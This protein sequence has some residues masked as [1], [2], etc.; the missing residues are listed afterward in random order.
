MTNSGAI[1]DRVA[2]KLGRL[3]EITRILDRNREDAAFANE[4]GGQIFYVIDTNVVNSFFEPFLYPQYAEIFQGGIWGKDYGEYE[5]F[6]RQ[7]CLLTAEYLMSG[8]LPGQ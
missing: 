5:F 7:S 6:N 4:G 8:E 1:V 2:R 3:V